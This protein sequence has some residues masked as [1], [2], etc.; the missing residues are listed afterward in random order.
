MVISNGCY[1]QQQ[2]ATV[3]ADKISPTVAG[4][5]CPHELRIPTQTRSIDGIASP[6]CPFSHLTYAFASSP[7]HV[8]YGATATPPT[9]ITWLVAS[10][11]AGRVRTHPTQRTSPRTCPQQRVFRN[12]YTMSGDF[13]WNTSSE[14]FMNQPAGTTTI[15]GHSLQSR[16]A[17][18]RPKV[19]PLS[20]RCVSFPRF[21]RRLLS[22]LDARL[23]L[24]LSPS[25]RCQ[26]LARLLPP[27]APCGSELRYSP[28][29]ATVPRLARTRI[30]RIVQRLTQLVAPK[31]RQH[32]VFT[33][34]V[35]LQ[36]CFEVRGRLDSSFARIAQNSKLRRHPIKPL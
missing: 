31:A 34:G 22:R 19:R 21:S 17:S 6:S 11:A 27:D 23:L 32:C 14:P 9:R 26:T 29:E 24:L 15:S 12:R 28:Y 2:F 8:D 3:G 7:A 16:K 35:A 36:V 33:F 4:S 10:A 18:A 20:F 1:N 13:H 5:S 25:L 30:R